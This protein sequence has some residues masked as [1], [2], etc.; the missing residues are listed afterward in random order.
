MS[1]ITRTYVVALTSLAL[2]AGA[3]EDWP[4]FRGPNASGVSE[5]ARPPHEFGPD[6]SVVWKAEVPWSPGSLCVVNGR[7][8]LNAFED[9][10]L[11]TRAYAASNG[12]L[13][14]TGV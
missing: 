9:G 8:F 12:K 13:L 1:H 2:V 10:K 4:M 14:W 3:G 6:Q 7:V 11:E 5:T